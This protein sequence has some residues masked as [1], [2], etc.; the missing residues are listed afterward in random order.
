MAIRPETRARMGRAASQAWFSRRQSGTLARNECVPRAEDWVPPR[1]A[2]R[3]WELL[4]AIDL[5]LLVPIVLVLPD[6]ALEVTDHGW[7]LELLWL[8]IPFGCYWAFAKLM[9][10]VFVPRRKLP[11]ENWALYLAE[12]CAV[13]ITAFLWFG[14]AWV[15]TWIDPRY[16]LPGL[17]P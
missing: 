10:L 9:A 16:Y 2:H 15:Y 1:W 4:T 8:L 7:R 11:R 14:L 13:W 5:T 17:T 12:Q 6:V 3:L